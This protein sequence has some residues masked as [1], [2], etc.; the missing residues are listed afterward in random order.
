MTKPYSLWAASELNK[1]MQFSTPLI[2]YTPRKKSLD[3][4]RKGVGGGGEGGWET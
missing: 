1:Y 4:A 3:V 2:L